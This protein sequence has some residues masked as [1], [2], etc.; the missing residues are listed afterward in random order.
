MCQ[1]ND[2]ILKPKNISCGHILDNVN[3][4][5]RF[6]ILYYFAKSR[7]LLYLY[8]YRILAKL[9]CDDSFREISQLASKC[10]L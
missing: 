7:L 10:Y 9:P 6:S 8:P 4:W 2:I 3:L 1:E 5:I